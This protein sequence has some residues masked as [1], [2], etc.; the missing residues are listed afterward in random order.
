LSDVAEAGKGGRTAPVRRL[1]ADRTPRRV[2]DVTESGEGC[3]AA[4]HRAMTGAVVEASKQEQ[5]TTRAAART[6]SPGGAARTQSPEAAARRAAPRA[7]VRAPM[8]GAAVRAQAPR[9]A[10]GARQHGEWCEADGGAEKKDG[11]RPRCCEWKGIR[12]MW[13]RAM[14][15][16][17]ERSHG[18]SSLKGGLSSETQTRPSDRTDDR[19][20]A[21]P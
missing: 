16:R 13:T 6:Q 8:P 4:P 11:R 19:H 17:M 2:V 20:L 3:R 7:E 10:G 5:Q 18:R 14:V 12:N 1:L 15:K 21:F 9:A